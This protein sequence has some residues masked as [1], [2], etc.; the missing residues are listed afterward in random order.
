M[1]NQIEDD[2]HLQ[3][4]NVILHLSM[5]SWDHLYYMNSTSVIN[6]IQQCCIL[7]AQIEECVEKGG[8]L[9]TMV[10]KN[11]ECCRARVTTQ[12]TKYNIQFK[13]THV[14]RVG[15]SRPMC[16]KST[17]QGR[18]SAELSRARTTHILPLL[19]VSWPFCSPHVS[20]DFSVQ[21]PTKRT[22]YD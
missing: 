14:W 22:V 17:A 2:K 10:T 1:S 11:G 7:S 4:D 6:F 9:W 3:P 13:G 18:S 21:D 5:H 12:Y 19:N 20:E 15:T 8:W 16:S